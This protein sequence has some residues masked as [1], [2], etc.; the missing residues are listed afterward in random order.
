M[1]KITVTHAE[2]T[3]IATVAI[4]NAVN[5]LLLGSGGVGGPY[6]GAGRPVILAECQAITL[7]LQ[8]SLVY[9]T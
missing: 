6:H 5:S 2:I 4:V 9:L 8:N 3:K 7:C 1:N